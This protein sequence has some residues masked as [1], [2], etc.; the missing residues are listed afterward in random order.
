V[1]GRGERRGPEPAPVLRV[2]LMGCGRRRRLSVET[3]ATQKQLMAKTSAISVPVSRTKRRPPLKNPRQPIVD[4]FA[5]YVEKLLR[6]TCENRD[7]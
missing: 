3:P 6:N 7:T 1:L 4:R 5:S 2:A